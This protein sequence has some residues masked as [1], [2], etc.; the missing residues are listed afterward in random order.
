MKEVQISLRQSI[1]LEQLLVN[2]TVKECGHKHRFSHIGALELGEVD[3]CMI[4][5]K[6]LK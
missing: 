5:N 6:D 3:S 1:R 2:A 4:C